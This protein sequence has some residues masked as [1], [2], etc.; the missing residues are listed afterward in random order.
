MNNWV[1][2]VRRNPTPAVHQWHTAPNA[3]CQDIY[4]FLDAAISS[5]DRVI[6]YVRE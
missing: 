4:F 5:S 6:L 3:L 2:R 1:R